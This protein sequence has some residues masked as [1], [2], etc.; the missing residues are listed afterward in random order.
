MYKIDRIAGTVLDKDKAKGLVTLLT[1]SGVVNVKI[2]GPVFAMYDKRI[3]EI[4]ED[5]KKHVIEESLLSR[6]N[7]IIVTGIRRGDSF[8]CKKYKKN[9]CNYYDMYYGAYIIVS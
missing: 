2:F 6:G 9:N 8:I 1:T 7:K 4:G 5:G 3:S